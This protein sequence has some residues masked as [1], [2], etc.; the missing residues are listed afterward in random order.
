MFGGISYASIGEYVPDLTLVE[1]DCHHTRTFTE[2]Y[3]GQPC[4]AALSID[5]HNIDSFW[6]ENLASTCEFY[7]STAAL[8]VTDQAPPLDKFAP[9]AAGVFVG[10]VPSDG[11]AHLVVIED[12][13]AGEDSRSRLLTAHEAIR[14][15]V[16]RYPDPS[17]S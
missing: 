13:I 2:A 4:E 16:C 12:Q 17:S 10:K 6:L 15:L 14:K 5:P 11:F 3:S 1:L 9:L 8:V 7:G